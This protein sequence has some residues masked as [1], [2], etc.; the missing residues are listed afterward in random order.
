MC[1]RKDH[2][3]LALPG[4]KRYYVSSEKWFS[5]QRY[6]PYSVGVAAKSRRFDTEGAELELEFPPD[7]QRVG[8]GSELEVSQ[9]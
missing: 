9:S 5:Q 1:V 6:R 8:A 4:A 2:Q 7:S 3:Y